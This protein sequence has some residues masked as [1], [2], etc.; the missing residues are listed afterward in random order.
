MFA[1]LPLVLLL[2][3][4]VLMANMYPLHINSNAGFGADPSYQYLFAGVDILLGH[5]PVHTD[6]PGT[7]L[8]TL[9]AGIIA[10]TWVGL[11][12]LGV[13]SA[14]LFDSVLLMPEVF[15]C[16]TSVF[17]LTLT[18]LASFYLGR[19]AYKVTQNFSMA[20]AFQVA[21]LLYPIVIPNLV[22]PTPEA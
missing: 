11:R 3:G 8:Q 18:C 10:T 5:S 13:S 21:P 2:I 22:F 9:I 20:L 17:L 15:L 19:I 12:I 6:H 14:G 1:A 4:V 7:P 16:A